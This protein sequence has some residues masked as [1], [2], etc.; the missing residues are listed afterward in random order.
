MVIEWKEASVG[1][2]INIKRCTS[3]ST[4]ASCLGRLQPKQRVAS[5]PRPVAHAIR[6]Q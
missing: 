2:T 5:E 6:E 4:V 3:A 1:G